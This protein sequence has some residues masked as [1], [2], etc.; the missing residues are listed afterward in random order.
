MVYMLEQMLDQFREHLKLP[1]P[2]LKRVARDREAWKQLTAM[3]G[4]ARI[5]RGLCR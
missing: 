5:L 2:T 4:G 1:L 3:E